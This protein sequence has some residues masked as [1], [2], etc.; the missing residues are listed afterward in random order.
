V[1]PD[2]ERLPQELEG[3]VK[4]GHQVEF[5]ISHLYMYFANGGYQ[6]QLPAKVSVRVAR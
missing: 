6:E 5:T 2:P 3:K 1:A 4:A